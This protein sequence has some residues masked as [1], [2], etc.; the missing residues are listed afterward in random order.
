MTC[1]ECGRATTAFAIP[2]EL[3]EYVPENASAAAIC[4]SCLTLQPPIEDEPTPADPD[5]TVISE[6]FPRDPAAAIPMALMIGLLDSLALNRAKIAELIERVENEGVDPMLLLEEL[7]RDSSLNPA[8]DLAGRK[9]Q[10]EQ[11]LE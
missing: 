1:S 5:L 3:R 7:A 11:L 2:E 10:L 6:S 4:P 9:R 8:I